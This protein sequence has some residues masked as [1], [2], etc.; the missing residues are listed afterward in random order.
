MLTTIIISLVLGYQVTSS[1]ERTALDRARN[2]L[3][4]AVHSRKPFWLEGANP[5]AELSRLHNDQAD[6]NAWNASVD[7]MLS[8]YAVYRVKVWSQSSRIVW[9]DD[10][11]IIGQTHP[12]NDELEEALDGSVK[13]ELTDLSKVE[14][15]T[16]GVNG[17]VLELYVP[18]LAQNSFEV[19]GAFE[20]YQEVTDMY[21]TV[22]QEQQDAV[23]LIAVLMG[24]FYLALFTM[25]A[26]ASSTLSR[27]Q[28][29]AQLER[30]FS[31]AVAQ[32]IASM[33][34]QGILRRHI[35]APLTSRVGATV[36]FTDIRG[37]TRHAEHMEP[38]DVVA[39]LSD[40]VDLVSSAVF[41][42]G[43]SVDKF[44]GDGI[45]AVFGA[46]IAQPNHAGNALRAADEIRA[47]LV[48]LNDMRTKMGEPAIL[49]GTS[50]ATGEVVTG[51]LGRGAQLAYTVVGDT[52]NLASRLVGLARP[53]EVLVTAT[54][55]RDGASTGDTG[56]FDFSGPFTLRVR[57]RDE[58]VTIYASADS[59]ATGEPPDETGFTIRQLAAPGRDSVYLHK[60]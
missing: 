43:G 22:Q 44:L 7:N 59:Q 9:S 3:A 55:Y 38:E 26:N 15:R 58:A 13:S 29:I 5:K 56:R 45:L 31:P 8:G 35:T 6:W 36:M 42:H 2:E 30:Y 49:I 20:I 46:P 48:E 28:R 24:T 60:R 53:G 51:T 16:D 52:V 37:F 18:I 50:L 27:L 19:I 40:Y 25:I 39:M 17:K 21:E 34:S 23:M 33:G 41:K 4:E 12:E 1:I 54:T 10:K 47:R 32:A 57:G 14:N 11:G